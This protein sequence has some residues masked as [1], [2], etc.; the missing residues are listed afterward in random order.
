MATQARRGATSSSKRQPKSAPERAERAEREPDTVVGRVR[1]AGRPAVVGHRGAMGTSP[2]NTLGSF[3]RAVKLGAD[4]IELD[5]HLSRDGVPVVIHDDSLARTTSGR[6]A[7]A[8]RTAAQLTKLD[9][10]SWFGDA[11]AAERV[12]T[13]EQTLTWADGAG[14]GVEIELKNC[15]IDAPGVEVAVVDAL[16]RT[17]MLDR[18][19]VIGFDHALVKRVKL[20]S[21]RILTGIL[22]ACRP[23]DELEMARRAKADVLLPHWSFVTEAGV[24]A[25]HGAGLAVAPW[26][27]SERAVVRALLD[28]GVD[29]ITTDHP[30]SVRRLVR[31]SR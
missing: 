30:D 23:V 18:A 9:A 27:T 26:T 25:A 10:G 6:G 24:A 21:K 5:V 22:Y 19:M 3:A 12:P 14:V 1:R 7:V 4:W 28:A 17:G 31:S 13:L 8:S 2:E 11:W 15:P 20:L 29:A 16:T